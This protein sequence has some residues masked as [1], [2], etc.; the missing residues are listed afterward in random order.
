[1][2]IPHIVLTKRLSHWNGSRR[3][4]RMLCASGNESGSVYQTSVLD[5]IR[6]LG[7]LLLH[8]RTHRLQ[9]KTNLVLYYRMCTSNSFIKCALLCFFTDCVHPDVH[10]G[11]CHLVPHTE[12][13]SDVVKV[14]AWL[15]NHRGSSG[16]GILSLLRSYT[17]FLR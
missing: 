9:A 4:L 6:I 12:H 2:S 8:Y 11:M 13:V 1:M 15:P 5:C 14:R 17:C 3:S 10:S 7:F 16:E